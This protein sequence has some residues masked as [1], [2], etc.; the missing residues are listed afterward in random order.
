MSIQKAKDHYLGKGGLTKANCAEAIIRAFK[1][2]FNI[3][4]KNFAGYGKG[5]A[6]GGLCG[7]YCAAKEIIEKYYP[8]RKAEFEKFFLEKAGNLVCKDIRALRKLSCLGC[9]EKAAEFVQ[10]SITK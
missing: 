7:A 1:E 8:E 6:P 5:K 4:D 3:D 10:R 2:N 9:V